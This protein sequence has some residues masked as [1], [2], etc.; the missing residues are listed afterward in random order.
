MQHLVVSLVKAFDEGIPLQPIWRCVMPF[1]ACAQGSV[2]SSTRLSAIDAWPATCF[3][4]D[5]GEG[6]R[7]ESSGVPRWGRIA[8][9]GPNVRIDWASRTSL[10]PA[11]ISLDHHGKSIVALAPAKGTLSSRTSPNR[12]T[13]TDRQ[14]AAGKINYVLTLTVTQAV[15]CYTK[16][17]L[18][19]IVAIGRSDGSECRSTA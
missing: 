4:E 19:L 18:T 10:Q 9:K 7:L 11:S 13:G 8:A 3:D 5:L 6:A 15:F 2:A 16:L 17:M 14:A 1:N 12:G